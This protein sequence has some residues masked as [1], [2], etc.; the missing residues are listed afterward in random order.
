MFRGARVISVA[1]ILVGCASPPS[2]R[3]DE[4][5]AVLPSPD[6]P[7]HALVRFP[8]DATESALWEEG[9]G[10]LWAVPEAEVGED[11]WYLVF[12]P[13]AYLDQLVGTEGIEWRAATPGIVRRSTPEDVVVAE[14]SPGG[15]TVSPN[16]AGDDPCAAP[17]SATHANMFCPYDPTQVSAHP[18]VNCNRSIRAEL[19]AAPTDY[20]N[21]TI[22]GTST[23]YV[24][25]LNLGTVGGQVIRGVRVGRLYAGGA[26]V[27]Q[28]VVY[29]G[30]HSREWAT[31]ETVLRNMRWFASSFRDNTNGVRA[32]LSDRAIV[33]I[34]VVNVAGYRRTHEGTADTFRRW[35]PNFTSCGATPSG[36]DLNRNAP[37]SYGQPGSSASCTTS[38][39]SLFR[40]PPH[41]GGI[42]AE[43]AALLAAF[44]NP[45]QYRTVLSV[46]T[47]AY[48]NL[49]L[50]TEGLSSSFSPCTTDSNC[51][52]PD[53]GLFYDLAGTERA[54]RM[55]DEEISTV[56]YRTA[57]TTRALYAV[58][59][60][61]V[62]ETVYG[63]LPAST[64]R[65]MSI[66]SEISRTTCG[67]YAEQLPPSQ[68]TTLA[69]NYRAFQ[70]HLLRSP[71]TFV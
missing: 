42:Q 17:T 25:V 36:T 5:R 68:L 53:L 18:W 40:G 58:S 57:Q 8:P 70:Q 66:A 51:T 22:G 30:Q 28:V 55:R 14:R 69:D 9:S 45:T 34:P 39:D 20:P 50:F 2:S 48:G 24:Q 56:P 7:I 35:R 47:H 29:G 32:L 67:F 31:S 19:E 16:F 65:F 10:L 60:D 1:L 26:P 59:G 49:L 33:F 27:P 11:G 43:T 6:E 61:T 54:P 46:N 62:T 38:A 52:A 12:L 41:P 71:I 37:L 3:S 4:L 44:A 23:S 13:A 63:T 64:P 15:G 21:V